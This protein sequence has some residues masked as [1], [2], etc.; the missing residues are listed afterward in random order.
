MKALGRLYNCAL[1]HAQSMICQSCDRGHQYCSPHCAAIARRS[2]MKRAQHRYAVS[3]K[4]RLAAALR[5]RRFRARKRQLI[6]PSEPYSKPPDT[7]KVTHH[8]SATNAQPDSL[9]TQPHQRLW[10]PIFRRTRRQCAGR[11]HY[12]CHRC[13]DWLEFLRTT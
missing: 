12:Q 8:S 10:Q 5:Q 7:K 9:P 6:V 2:H 3:H 13:G 1:C 11:T 4:G